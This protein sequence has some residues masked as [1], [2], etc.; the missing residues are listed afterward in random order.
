M[1]RILRRKNYPFIK[2]KKDLQLFLFRVIDRI[3]QN[4]GV[5]VRKV[6]PYGNDGISL[7]GDW[8][9]RISMRI[10]TARGILH[11]V[12]KAE[13]MVEKLEVFNGTRYYNKEVAESM[14]LQPTCLRFFAK[15]MVGEKDIFTVGN[16]PFEKVQ[17][18]QHTLLE[19]GY[20][21]FSMMEY[22]PKNA[23]DLS[24]LKVDGGKSLPYFN[25]LVD[26]SIFS[27]NFGMFNMPPENRIS[28]DEAED[29]A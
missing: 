5:K 23:F 11:K 14:S 4:S 17:E 8:E 2:I 12:T 26:T 24:K 7:D 18:I 16:L 9:R 1:A 22:Q 25:E 10:I 28:F 27:S 29:E 21:D 20:Y 3:P 19:K 15:A 13:P 6:E